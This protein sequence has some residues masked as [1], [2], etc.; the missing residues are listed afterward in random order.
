MFEREHLPN[1]ESKRQEALDGEKTD[2]P[3]CACG[4]ASCVPRERGRAGA[5][6]GS[7]TN[8]HKQGRGSG[9]WLCSNRISGAAVPGE[10]TSRAGWFQLQLLPS[11]PSERLALPRARQ[12]RQGDRGSSPG[13]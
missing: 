2:G 11:A 10:V 12:D 13:S 8:M 5:S 1:L 6:A 4:H 7:S 3:V 9:S